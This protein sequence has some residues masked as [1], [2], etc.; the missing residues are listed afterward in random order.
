M[1]E[2]QQPDHSTD[3]LDFLK[4]QPAAG[5]SMSAGT[6]RNCQICRQP[7]ASQYF[8]VQGKL[9][10]PSCRD[11][12]VNLPTG[13]APLQFLRATLLGLG[14]GLVGTVI[15]F[16]I[17][18]AANLEIGWIALLV[19]FMVGKA[20]RIGSGNRG[21]RVYQIL[22]VVLTYICIE[23]NYFPDI[24]E[25]FSKVAQQRHVNVN[26]IAALW[27]MVLFALKLPFLNAE[28]HPIGLFIKG[29][30][31]FEAWKFTQR[32]PLAISGPYQLAPV[33]AVATP[34]I[35]AEPGQSAGPPA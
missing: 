5:S 9:I 13:I 22:A 28:Q 25:A 1:A 30:A 10:C 19:G 35:V 14:A 4:A 33:A 31:L 15:W 2:P 27:P 12:L 17:R 20:V 6:A 8:A 21:G 7:I 24:V 32:R 16:A 34:I 29:L 3:N 23:A 26:W 18:R 11:R